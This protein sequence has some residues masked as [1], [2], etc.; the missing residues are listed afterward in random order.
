[1]SVSSLERQL[2]DREGVCDGLR[3]Q[4][5]AG[6]DSSAR[7]NELAKQVHT[8]SSRANATDMHITSIYAV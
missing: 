5:D 3:R 1:M 6:G 2:L 4:L 7:E 8:A